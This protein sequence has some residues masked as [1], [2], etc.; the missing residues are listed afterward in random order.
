MHKHNTR[1]CPACG[2]GVT[3]WRAD[4]VNGYGITKTWYVGT[5]DDDNDAPHLPSAGDCY[6]YGTPLESQ[7]YDRVT[8]QCARGRQSA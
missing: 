2:H 3:L 5:H 6:T 1:L 4:G 8:R 7:A